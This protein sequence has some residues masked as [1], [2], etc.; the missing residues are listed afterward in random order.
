MS[1][2]IEYCCISS[3]SLFSIPFND[4]V[5]ANMAGRNIVMLYCQLKQCLLQKYKAHGNK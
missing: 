5:N 3:I 2:E 1:R 4:P